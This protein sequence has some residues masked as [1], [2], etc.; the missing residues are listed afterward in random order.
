VMTLALDLK[1]CAYLLDVEE[2]KLR[3]S[4]ERGEIRGLKLGNEWRISIFELARVLETSPDEILEY[5]EDIALAKMIQEVEEDE[6]FT[7]EEGRSVYET[8]LHGEK[9]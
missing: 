9:D 3:S 2:P 1:T 7:P 5:L 6:S 4:V 8:Y